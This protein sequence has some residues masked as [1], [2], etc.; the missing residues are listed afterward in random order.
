MRLSDYVL[1]IVQLKIYYGNIIMR[2]SDKWTLNSQI[3]GRRIRQA[4]E[5]QGLSQEQ[6]AAALGVG[7]RAISEIENGKQRLPVTDLPELARALNVPL[8]HFFEE[9][10]SSDDLDL[11]LLK[12]FHRLPDAKSR[13]SVIEIVRLISETIAS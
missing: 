4:R 2:Y 10:L 5:K 13:H 8:L 6:L 11:A 7:Q 1:D 9:E 3:L 12:H